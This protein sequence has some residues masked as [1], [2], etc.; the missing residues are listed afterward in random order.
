MLFYERV[1]HNPT[2][3]FHFSPIGIAEDCSFTLRKA[4]KLRSG[5]W[6]EKKTRSPYQEYQLEGPEHC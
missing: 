3:K 2:G 6:L 4:S 1:N 5:R